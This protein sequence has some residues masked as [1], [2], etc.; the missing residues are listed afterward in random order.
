M[1]TITHWIGGKP[2]E[3]GS[4]RFGPVYDPATGAQDTQVALA[5][6]EEVDAAVATAKAAFESWGTASLA[7]RTATRSPR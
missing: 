3:G 1:K 4:G 7:R 5:T 6:V 2:V